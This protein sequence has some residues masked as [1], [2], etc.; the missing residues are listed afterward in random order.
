MKRIIALFEGKKSYIVSFVIAAYNLAVAFGW[1]SP[2]TMQWLGTNGV[3]AGGLG[4][5]IRAAI[6]KM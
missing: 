3:M 6:S 2:S 5:A 1:I 4:A